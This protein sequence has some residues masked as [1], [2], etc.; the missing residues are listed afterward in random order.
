VTSICQFL[1]IGSVV[2]K[3]VTKKLGEKDK[4]IIVEALRRYKTNRSRQDFESVLKA[5]GL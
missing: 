1:F 5:C 3:Q 4:K 2:A